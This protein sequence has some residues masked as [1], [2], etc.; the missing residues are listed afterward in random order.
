MF[1]QGKS[2]G[3]TVDMWS[4]FGVSGAHKETEAEGMNGNCEGELTFWSWKGRGAG[5]GNKEM[6][7]EA[8]QGRPEVTGHVI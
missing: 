4:R 2:I 8:L 5:G 1:G 6:K 7:I 3:G